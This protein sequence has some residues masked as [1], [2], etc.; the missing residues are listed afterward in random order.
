ME[1]ENGGG[2]M[3]TDEYLYLGAGS[4]VNMEISLS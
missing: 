2:L 3:E 4:A 1:R